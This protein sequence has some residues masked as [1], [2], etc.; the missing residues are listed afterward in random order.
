MKRALLLLPLV[1]AG[2]GLSLTLAGAQNAPAKPEGP[3]PRDIVILYE[4]DHFSGRSAA[5]GTDTPDLTTVNF[6][7]A[8]SSL[9][10]RWGWQATFFEDSDGKGHWWTFNCSEPIGNKTSEFCEIPSISERIATGRWCAFK[11]E[12]AEA[13]VKWWNDRITGVM[14]ISPANMAEPVGRM[15]WG[16][17]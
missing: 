16:E 10:L 12:G 7:D 5:I 3:R 11:P 1:A 17:N 2:F 8:A 13:C 6:N 15:D 4:H 9:R 14:R